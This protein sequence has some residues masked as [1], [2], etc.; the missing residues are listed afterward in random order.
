[1]SSSERDLPYLIHIAET[2]ELVRSAGPS[3]LEA[4][5][6]DPNLRD[7]TLCR[8]QTRSESASRSGRC[9]PTEQEIVLEP[10]AT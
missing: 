6:A 9:A 8:L 5:E 1:M 2:V 10:L 4:L 7:A 3:S